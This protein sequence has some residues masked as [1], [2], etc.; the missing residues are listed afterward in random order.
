MFFCFFIFS[1]KVSVDDNDLDKKRI[2]NVCDKI[3]RKFSEGRYIQSMEIL[4]QNSVMD[5]SSINSLKETITEQMTNVFPDFGKMK[6]YDF[7]KEIKIKDFIIKRYYILKFEKYF[8]SFE[9]VLYK[10]NA[11]WTITSFKYNTDIDAVIK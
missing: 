2:E 5:S 11:D 6:T 9:F 8:L 1:C 3:M 7:V 4:N 10:A